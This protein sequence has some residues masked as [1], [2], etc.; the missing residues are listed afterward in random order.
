VMDIEG[1]DQKTAEIIMDVGAGLGGN[2]T[3]GTKNKKTKTVKEVRGLK[4]FPKTRAGQLLE[5]LIEVQ[6]E[7]FFFRRTIPGYLELMQ[8]RAKL[9]VDSPEYIELCAE[10]ARIEHNALMAKHSN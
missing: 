9:K 5:R 7:D 4:K 6:L 2:A 3:I 10:I 8:Q 1:I